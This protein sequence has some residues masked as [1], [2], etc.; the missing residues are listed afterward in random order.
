[1]GLG[2]PPYELSGALQRAIG[3]GHAVAGIEVAPTRDL[4]HPA[5]VIVQNFTYLSLD[6]SGSL[7]AG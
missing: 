5:D 2:G 7:G 6:V 3:A 1:M 4:T